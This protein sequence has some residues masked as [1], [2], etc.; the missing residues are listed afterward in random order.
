MNN[1]TMKLPTNC[2]LLDENDLAAVDGGALSGTAQTVLTVGVIGA[3]VCVGVAL[4]SNL[5]GGGLRGLIDSSVNA[6]QDFIDGSLSAGQDILDAI[7]PN[8]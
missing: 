7:T 8:V 5:F 4:L 2:A 3:A 6:G 1:E